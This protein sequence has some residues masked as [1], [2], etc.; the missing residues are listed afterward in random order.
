MIIRA[1]KRENFTMISNMP[2][3]DERLSAEAL[4]VLA[5]LLSFSDNWRLTH[6]D[7]MRRLVSAEIRPTTL[8]ENLERPD[9]SSK[10][11]SGIHQ[12]TS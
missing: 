10:N 3:R 5:Y 12:G 6:K 7:L 11:C 2:I 4:G 1:R 9:I 8:F